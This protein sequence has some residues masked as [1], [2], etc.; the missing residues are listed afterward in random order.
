M[1]MVIK[2]LILWCSL[3]GYSGLLPPSE[4]CKV[5]C[6]LY[7]KLPEGLNV[8]VNGWLSSM[9][10]PEMKQRPVDDDVSLRPL[11]PLMA[12]I[13]STTMT[14]YRSKRE[15]SARQANSCMM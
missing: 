11:R 3:S 9:F 1:T 8:S 5:N 6:L 2:Q 12:G 7:A 10:S 15:I 13:G 4:T 14:L